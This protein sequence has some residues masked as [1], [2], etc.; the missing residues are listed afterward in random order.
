MSFYDYAR[1]VSGNIIYFRYYKDDWVEITR[2]FNNI[3]YTSLLIGFAIAFAAGY[4]LSRTITYPLAKLMRKAESIAK[5]DFDQELEVKSGDE[6]GKLADTFNYMATNLKN[7][8]IEI[9]SEKSKLETILNYM[10]DG[11]IAFNLKGEVIHTNPASARILG[12]DADELPGI[13]RPLRFEYSLEDVLYL[14]S[15]QTTEMNLSVGDKSIKVYFAVFTDES[16]KPEGV[17]AVLQDITEQQRLEEM[18][19]EFVAN[20]SHE[21]RTPLTSIK[22]YSETLLDGAL[23]DRETAEHFLTVI[24]NESDRMTRLIR[25]L[26]QLSRLDNQQTRWN[27]EKMSLAELV[28]STV[29]RMKI[30]VDSRRQKIECFVI[31]EIPEIEGDYGRLE[32]VAFNIIGNAV[33]YTPE[34]GSITVYI[35]KIY[36]DVYFK[37][38]D[39]GIGIP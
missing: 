21:L 3:I 7:N 12:A 36:N 32:Q 19:K 33:K 10:T 39:T 9:S 28:K 6:I 17:I 15:R 35:G 1:P 22:S 13:P 34:G 23:D 31:N 37:V 25:D 26:L 38:S 18:R 24:N 29:E 30:E 11:I 2:Y 27:F 16:K 5:G 8:L 20:V 14:Q 4:F